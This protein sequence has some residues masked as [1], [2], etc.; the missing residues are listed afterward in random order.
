MIDLT[1]RHLFTAVTHPDSG[2]T[3]HVLTKRVAPVQQ[4]FYYVNDSMSADG[5]YL[6]FYC[7]FPPSLFKTLGVVDLHT[8]EV[9]HFP[10]TQFK[11][12][13]PYVD[14][15]TGEAFWSSGSAVWRRGAAANESASLV[16]QLPEEVSEGRP[17]RYLGTHLTR[18][19][20]GKAFFIDAGIGL[21]YVF[22][23]LPLNGGDF[24]FWWRFDRCHNHAQLSPTDAGEVLFAQEIHN[25]PITGLTLPITNR[26]WTMRKGQPP[27]PILQ[28]DP[29]C[30]THEWW[31]PDGKHVWCVDGNDTWRVC[32][33]DGNVEKIAFPRHCW[34]SHTTRDG[35]LIVGDSNNGFFRGCASTVHFMN[36]NTGKV[37]VIAEHAER[38]DYAGRHYHIDPHPRFCC[39]DRYV[40]F[41]TTVRDQVDVAI[42]SVEH[43]IEKTS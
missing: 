33:V 28:H 16:N 2:V 6:W 10:E 37:I 29:K 19:A 26:L 24:D 3:S 5:R 23:A 17:V 18:S 35:S 1:N 43:L 11:A 41:T 42:V 39:N 20:D 8:G 13:S 9:R 38:L 36:R 31:D 30:V 22:G 4:G 40:I 32:T 7:A 21:Q 27:R 34:H 25:D 12:E 15:A 14:P